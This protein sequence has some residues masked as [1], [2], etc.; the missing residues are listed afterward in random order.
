MQREKGLHAGGYGLS[1]TRHITCVHDIVTR[2]TQNKNKDDAIRNQ[3]AR[4]PLWCEAHHMRVIP[5][6]AEIKRQPEHTS[7]Q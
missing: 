5:S 2:K 3:T 1:G 7:A 6:G 4:W